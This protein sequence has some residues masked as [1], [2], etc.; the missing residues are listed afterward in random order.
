MLKA[1]SPV[2][3]TAQLRSF[4]G[5]SLMRTAGMHMGTM[6]HPHRTVPM[7]GRPHMLAAAAMM[8]HQ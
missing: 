5:K 8:Y 7:S 6:S 1:Y 4:E 3:C 2:V